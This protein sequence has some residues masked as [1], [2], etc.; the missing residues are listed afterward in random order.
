MKRSAVNLISHG[1]KVVIVLVATML[2]EKYCILQYQSS[3]G[4]R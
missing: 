4:N 3:K 2:I 1:N